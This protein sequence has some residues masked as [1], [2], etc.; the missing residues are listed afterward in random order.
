[1]A[2]SSRH[3]V[4]GPT[5]TAPPARPIRSPETFES[6]LRRE[7]AASILQSY[8]QLSWWSFKRCESLA[9]TRI[10]FQNIVAGYTPEDERALVDYEEDKTPRKSKDVNRKGHRTSEGGASDAGVGPSGSR[11]IAHG[12]KRKSGG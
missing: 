8:E 7:E 9:Q 1:M 4:A 6:L 10:H 3:S 2:L 5:S 11:T 12:K